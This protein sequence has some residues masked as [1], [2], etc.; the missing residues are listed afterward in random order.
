MIENNNFS[1]GLSSSDGSFTSE[2]E[3][4]RELLSVWDAYSPLSISSL[5]IAYENNHSLDE[6]GVDPEEAR[7]CVN[8]Y[9]SIIF[10]GPGRGPMVSPSLAAAWVSVKM[11]TIVA[12]VAKRS[13]P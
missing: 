4:K 3:I 12:E 5:L 1:S 10:R 8:K 13:L 7:A 2:S 9:N 6:V 11:S